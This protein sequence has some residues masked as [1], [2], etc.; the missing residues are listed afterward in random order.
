MSRSF[1][2]TPVKL[3]SIFGSWSDKERRLESV[4]ACVV[5]NRIISQKKWTCYFDICGVGR[6]GERNWVSAV[7]YVIDQEGQGKT[8]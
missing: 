5:Q 1:D 2:T 7:A 8:R 3:V 4:P 6:V